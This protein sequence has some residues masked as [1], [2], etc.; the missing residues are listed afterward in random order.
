MR[1]SEPG[2]ES[3]LTKLK[4]MN[5]VEEVEDKNRTSGNIEASHYYQVHYLSAYVQQMFQFIFKF[6]ACSTQLSI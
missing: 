4:A 3:V 2:T 5:N 6:D 1:E